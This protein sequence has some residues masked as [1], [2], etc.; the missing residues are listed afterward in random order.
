MAK[1]ENLWLVGSQLAT[2]KFAFVAEAVGA[3]PP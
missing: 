2:Y 1:T 3:H